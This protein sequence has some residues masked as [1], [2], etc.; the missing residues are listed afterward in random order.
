MTSLTQRWK[1]IK[2]TLESSADREMMAVFK[3]SE[4]PPSLPTLMAEFT[5]K[6]VLEMLEGP[7]EVKKQIKELENIIV[8][9]G[10]ILDWI[11]RICQG[12]EVN[13]FAESFPIVRDVVD[14]KRSLKIS[15]DVAGELRYDLENNYIKRTNM[16]DHEMGG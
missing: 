13:E 10:S 2:I 8:L 4:N 6:D 9:Q 15:I 12:D 14:L 3:S 1:N 5:I 16:T 11:E 7:D